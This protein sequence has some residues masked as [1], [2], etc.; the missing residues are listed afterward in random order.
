MQITGKHLTFEETDSKEE[1]YFS[2]WLKEAHQKEIILDVYYHEDRFKL[3][4]EVWLEYL[5]KKKT[6]LNIK[7]FQLL[8]D[9][10]YSPDFRIVWNPAYLNKIFLCY[11][12]VFPIVSEKRPYM[13][14]LASVVNDLYISYVDTKGTFVSAKNSSGIRFPVEQKLLFKTKGI[15]VN[16][17]VVPTIFKDTF[18]PLRYFYQDIQKG[19][20]KI[21]YHAKT[22][23]EYINSI[24]L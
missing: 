8:K 19:R 9:H 1:T 21:N 10:W 3:I 12:P 6:K 15:Y 13:P 22:S 17:T 7:K 11:S 18:T 24:T 4:D 23:E 2:W 5:E 20:R 16:K 14:F